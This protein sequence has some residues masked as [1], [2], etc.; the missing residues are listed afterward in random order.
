[1]EKKVISIIV[2]VYNE[3]SNLPHL[4]DEI[5][6]HIRELPYVFE[7]LFVD[8]GSQDRSAEVARKLARHHR[9]VHVI[10][11]SRNFGKE[12]AVTAGLHHAKGDAAI[13]MDAD[14][15]M[16]PKLAC[17]F[18]QKWEDGADVV[19]GVFAARN[20]GRLR[21]FGAQTF[22]GLMQMIAHTK[23]TPHA[24]DYRLLDRKVIDA[25]NSMTERNRITRGLIDWLGFRREYIHFAQ[26]PRLNGEPTYSLR[27]LVQL[28]INSITSYSLVPLKLAGYLG[29]LI[30]TLSV[31][32][33][34][35][36]TIERFML[37]DP[38]HWGI[39]GTTLLAMLLVFLVGTVLACLGLISLY[40]GHIY[41]EVANRPLYVVRK[42]HELAE[43]PEEKLEFEAT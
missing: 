30:L 27:K 25:F 24:T 7:L 12:A 10:E 41:D 32:V 38:F 9:G 5:V 23:I 2:P 26:E 17:Q 18:I 1:M 22:Y 29:M 42:D 31:P 35:F 40:I 19:V 33:G 36:L 21:K 14:L 4:Y 28:A 11:L 3:A 20:M 16:P 37:H 13:M 8:D 6:K 34:I 39:N 43:T 15:Q